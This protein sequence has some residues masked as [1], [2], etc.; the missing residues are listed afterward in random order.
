MNNLNVLSQQLPAMAK[1][2]LAN[3]CDRLVGIK[4]VETKSIPFS[5]ATTRDDI[6]RILP[7]VKGPCIY[8]ISVS[9]DSDLLSMMKA[10]ATARKKKDR[11]YSKLNQSGKS[12]LY[13]GSSCTGFVKRINEHFG[14]GSKST[15][16]L[17]LCHWAQQAFPS[18]KLTLNYVEYPEDTDPELI[19]ILEDTLWENSEPMFGRKGSK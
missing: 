8:T 1:K 6:E 15:Y 9:K 3:I 2:H 19:Q 4:V 10:F 11:K 13:V 5:M 7:K 14:F 16:A 18:M 12:C 17:H